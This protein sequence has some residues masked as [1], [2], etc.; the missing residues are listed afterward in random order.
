MTSLWRA[1]AV[2][3]AGV[4]ASYRGGAATAQEPASWPGSSM[5]GRR[6]R[7]TC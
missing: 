2:M 1:G 3:P 4:L 7:I 5:R 6:T